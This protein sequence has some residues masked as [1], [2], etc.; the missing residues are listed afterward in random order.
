VKHKLPATTRRRFLSGAALTTAALGRRGSWATQSGQATSEP[1]ISPYTLHFAQPASKWPNALPVGNGRLGAMVFGVPGF[2]R[3]QLNEESIWDGEPNRDRNNPK[4]ASA[5][6]RI[7]E[8]LFAGQIEEAEQLAAS[9]LL[10]IP[11]RMPCYQTLGDLHLDFS[12]MGLTPEVAVEN[13]RLQLDLDTAI[14]TTTFTHAG[15]RHRREVFVSA[16]DQVIVVRLVVDQPGKLHVR[17]SLDRP[18][19]FQTSRTATNCLT[20]NGQALPVND[21]PGLPVKEHQTGVRF[22]AKLLT[23]PEGG[24]ILPAS[25][26]EDAAL[27]IAGA[28]AI[29]LFLDCATSYRYPAH[30]GK[31]GGVDADVLVGDPVAMRAAVDRNLR[32][33][34]SRLYAALRARHV[35]DHQRYF[36]R[37]DIEFGP[38]PKG[39]IPTDQ[40]VNAMKTGGEDI[41]LLP[42]YFQFGRY[43]LISSSR[44]GTL[45]ANLQGIWNESVDPPWGSKYTVNINAEMNYWLAESANLSECHLPLFDLLHAT[46]TPGALTAQETYRARGSVVHH[47]TDIW[48]DSGPIDGLGGGIWPMGGCWMSLHLWHH[49]AY[50][51]DRRFLAE[52]AYPAL[53]ENAVFLLDYLV[54]DPKTGHLTT[55]PSCSPE[56]AYQL[57]NGKSHNLCMGPTMDISIVREVFWRLLQ[58]AYL[59]ITGSQKHDEAGSASADREFLARVR[60]AMAELPPFE[61]GHDGRLQEWQLDYTD[62]EPGH[63]HISHL[64]GLFPGDQITLQATPEL[65]RAARAVLDKRLAAGGGSTG[66]SRAWI[67]NCMARL[68]DGEA[69][70]ANILELFRQ[71]TRPNLFDVCGLKENSPFQI[72]GNLGAPN[73]FIEM[74]LQSHGETPLAQPV[75]EWKSSVDGDAE[76]IRLLP[77]L[78]GAWASGS[79]RGLRARGGVEIDLEWSDGRAVKA[80]LHTSLARVHRVKTPGRQQ[81]KSLH[82]N[83]RA[84]QP[85]FAADGTLVITAEPGARYEIHF[86]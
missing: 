68:G 12:A 8:L 37:A 53:R 35:A 6:P 54:R 51:G 13:Y 76:V 45:A 49:Y 31:G 38:D 62:H 29:T 64:F 85:S 52:Y 28:N 2:D 22:H 43:M 66:W 40:R 25:E 81:V 80:T 67:I 30:A 74:L 18:H 34:S 15:V 17:L 32:A 9:D 59:L 50:G 47:N 27:E 20:L 63:R 16:P 77:A 56:N 48:G 19:S 10:S 72:D 69:C 24:K 36:R 75:S 83:G 41:H 1:S 26:R 14:A 42:I 70:Y 57:P 23:V 5:V 60:S 21:N 65:A 7:R 61:I 4:A 11:R 71:S 84:T 78:P 86:S 39:D 33:A 3:L 82:A 44:P 79:F 55:G 58:A 46:L 73:G